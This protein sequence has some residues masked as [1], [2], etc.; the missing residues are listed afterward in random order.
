MFDKSPPRVT[1]TFDY[2]YTKVRELYAIGERRRQ[3]G[4]VNI[5]AIAVEGQTAV[6]TKRF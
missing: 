5:S 4:K 6:P 3:S 1:C 2:G